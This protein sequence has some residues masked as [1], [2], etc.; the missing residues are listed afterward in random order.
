MSQERD[1]LQR[2]VKLS[3]EWKPYI[4]DAIDNSQHRLVSQLLINVW[5]VMTREIPSTEERFIYEC[6]F[7]MGFSSLNERF[8]LAFMQVSQHGVFDVLDANSVE[9][10]IKEGNILEL[11]EERVVNMKRYDI[12]YEEN[13]ANVPK[14]LQASDIIQDTSSLFGNR[15]KVIDLELV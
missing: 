2:I 11:Y 8:A 5:T 10:L 6:A 1:I 14:T 7:W 13:Y 15:G 3:K 4:A 9:S 12:A